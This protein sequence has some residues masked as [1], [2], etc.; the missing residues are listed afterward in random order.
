MFNEYSACDL[1]TLQVPMGM[2]WGD[3]ADGVRVEVL[4]SD[5]NLSTKVYWVAG[6]VKLAGNV[7]V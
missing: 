7:V 4:N 2:C 6:I 1:I 3:I 5:T